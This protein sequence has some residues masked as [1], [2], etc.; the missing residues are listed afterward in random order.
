MKRLNLIKF[1][2]E[3]QGSTVYMYVKGCIE[4]PDIE[5]REMEY[6]ENGGVFTLIGDDEQTYNEGNFT[7][8]IKDAQN[9]T[10]DEDTAIVDYGVCQLVFHV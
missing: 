6:I 10:S 9:I 1:L 5:I 7:V 4:I 8:D 3:R 2:K